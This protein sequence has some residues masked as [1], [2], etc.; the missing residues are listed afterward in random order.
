MARL[1]NLAVK[2]S[3]AQIVYPRLPKDPVHLSF[4]QFLKD[5]YAGGQQN[6]VAIGLAEKTKIDEEFKSR[7]IQLHGHNEKLCTTKLQ[8]VGLEMVRLFHVSN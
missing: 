4:A 5:T 6:K 8:E 1:P 2:A 7:L 3:K